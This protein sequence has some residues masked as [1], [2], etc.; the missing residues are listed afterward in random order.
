MV[1][2]VSNLVR[3]MN[4]DGFL[5]CGRRP[6]LNFKP[7]SMMLSERKLWV[8]HRMS[9]ETRVVFK[10]SRG[11]SILRGWLDRTLRRSAVFAIGFWGGSYTYAKSVVSILTTSLDFDW[12]SGVLRKVWGRSLAVFHDWLL[13]FGS[14]FQFFWR[15]GCT[16]LGSRVLTLLPGSV[17]WMCASR[18]NSRR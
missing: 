9:P 14:L 5:L 2:R 16:C 17:T 15:K 11:S 13:H 4:E 8:V 10:H 3:T 12:Q 6:S 1:H 7:F 18:Q